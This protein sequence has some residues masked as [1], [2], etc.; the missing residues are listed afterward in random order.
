MLLFCKLF[1]ICVLD[2]FM[3]LMIPRL[4]NV[5]LLILCDTTVLKSGYVMLYDVLVTIM[6][7]RSPQANSFDPK[8]N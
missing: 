5:E 1:A 3:L 6:C 7:Y 2:G 4:N 8:S